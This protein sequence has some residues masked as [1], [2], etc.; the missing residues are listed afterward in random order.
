M[1]L[2]LAYK[3]DVGDCRGSPGLALMGLLIREGPAVSY[4]DPHVPR[5]GAPGL[6]HFA[7]VSQPL[8]PDALAGQDAVVIVTD[9]SSYDWAFLVEHARLVL[10]TRNAT[11]GGGRAPGEG[12]AGLT[13]GGRVARLRGR[14]R[15]VPGAGGGTARTKEHVFH[16]CPSA[17]PPARGPLDE[18][19]RLLTGQSEDTIFVLD[20]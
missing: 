9:H 20:R 1:V 3:R 18:P 15:D 11:G 7:A 13:R 17:S 4:N 12:R 8:T 5:L 14:R 2:G 10:D 19:A 6:P 16:P